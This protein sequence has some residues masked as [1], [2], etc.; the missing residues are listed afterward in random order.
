MGVPDGKDLA[1]CNELLAS[2]VGQPLVQFR[3]GS[4]V[5]LELGRHFEV[6]IESPLTVTDGGN[7]WSGEPQTADAAGAL[8]PLRSRAV[9]FVK[10]DADGTLNLGLGEATVTVPP[11]PM[12]EA[13]RVRGPRGMLI[14]C[15]PGGEYVAVWRPRDAS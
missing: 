3:L 12:Y 6:T 15:S 2:A 14:V 1:L 8:L 9:T 10:V 13:W 11:D 5:D 7:C 4:G